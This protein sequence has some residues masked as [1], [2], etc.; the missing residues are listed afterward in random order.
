MIKGVLA[1][2]NGLIPPNILFNTPNPKIQFQKWKVQVPTA[3]TPWPSDGVRRMSVNSFGAGGTNAHAV[4]DGAEYYLR[5]RGYQLTATQE[6]RPGT[7]RGPN[8][9]RLYA[10]SSHDQD[11]LARQRESLA[12]FIQ[13]QVANIPSAKQ[14]VY[15]NRLAY[16]LSERRSAL[17]WKSFAVAADANQLV[18]E[19]RAPVPPSGRTKEGLRLGFIFTGQG[20]QWARM[21]MELR[22]YDIFQS[23]LESAEAFFKEKLKCPWSVI[24]EME[25]EEGDSHINSPEF[26]QA[27]CTVLQVAIVDL[28]SS[29][30]ITPVAVAGHSSGEIGAAYCL[31]ALT[32]EDAWS[33]AYWRGILSSQIPTLNPNLKGSMIAVG[34]SEDDVGKYIAR[35]SKGAI[36]VACVNSPSSVTVSGDTTGVD[37]LQE[38][39]REDGV[40][41]RKLKVGVAYHSSHMQTIAAQYLEAISDIETA[42][43]HPERT[44]HSS[45]SG[46]FVE[47]DELG[48]MYW[49]RNLTNPVRFSDALESLVLL[50][51]D[52]SG[53]R[54]KTAAVDIL[55]EIGPHS[56]LGGPVKQILKEIGVKDVEYQSIL[57][58]GKSA[59]QTALRCIGTLSVRGVPVEIKEVNQYHAC[60][61]KLTPLHDLPSYAW[62]HTRTFWA[63]PRVNR[64]YRF[65]EHPR[66]SLVGAPLPR[67]SE[68]ERDWKGMLRIS[69]EP[70]IR[71]HRIQNLVLYPAAGYI[72]MAIEGARQ[73][74][75]KS[76]EISAF[77]LRDIQIGAAATVTDDAD[78]EAMLHMRPHA[79]GTRDKAFSW[80]EFSISTCAPGQ[81]LRQNCAGLLLV[82][83]KSD[84]RSAMSIE[85][86]IAAIAATEQYADIKASCTAQEEPTKFY[87]DLASLGLNYGPT[88][89]L[90]TEIRLGQGVSCCT[91]EVADH[92]STVVPP[93]SVKRPYIIHPTTLDA[94]F[95]AVFAALKGPG[96]VLKGAM[97][98]KS[99]DQI[100]IAADIDIAEKSLFH[101]FA[102]ASK[103]G[104]KEIMSD[105]HMFDSSMSNHSVSITGFCCA[106]VAGSVELSDATADAVNL[107]TTSTWLPAIELLSSEQ[108]Q[109]VV[110]DLAANADV[111]GLLTAYEGET[112]KIKSRS[113]VHQVSEEEPHRNLKYL[114]DS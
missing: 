56:A 111:Y 57:S 54:V 74:A 55:I 15:L 110:K 70:W 68:N 3:L 94:M 18:E 17:P 27:L 80:W 106:D 84:E 36:S 62:N 37:E 22:Q 16:T 95:H 109:K 10:I 78:L 79:N 103:H 58:R 63:E 30:G 114:I 44:M 53:E 41:E 108:L 32:R 97:V 93:A 99:I 82:E 50:I 1:L 59:V 72:A 83:Y 14:D 85:N 42:E 43:S 86:E 4:L 51:D 6:I 28:L 47:A 19:L 26:S 75:D 21:G 104:F 34:L 92:G 38:L 9:P 88:F 25:R 113:M 23:S 98:P 52:E 48:P 76:R 66:Y 90:M 89:S 81:E 31:G 60:G 102:T 96:G 8:A 64:E 91:V 73:L 77:K 107:C 7:K 11:G 39:L 112:E 65:R 20:A 101:G 49:V 12:K 35:V 5:E 87:E 105:V 100:T 61:S 24:E 33:A 13:S 71:D 67:M 29:W 40:F 46:D 69:E 45:V 2:E